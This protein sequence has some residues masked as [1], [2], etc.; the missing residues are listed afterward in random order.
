MVTR[1]IVRKA[2]GH[3]GL[4]LLDVPYPIEP[5]GTG[6]LDIGGERWLVL[7]IRDIPIATRKSDLR[8]II[9]VEKPE[10]REYIGG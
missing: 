2:R 10:Y 8:R 9:R 4:S 5:D 1:T 7:E 6:W 3:F